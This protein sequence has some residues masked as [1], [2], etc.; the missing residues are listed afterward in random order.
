MYVAIGKCQ[1]LTSLFLRKGNNSLT[2]TDLCFTIQYSRGPTYFQV[3]LT[4]LKET[5]RFRKFGSGLLYADWNVY[6]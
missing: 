5:H 4:W 3:G 2:Q 6:I 1:M